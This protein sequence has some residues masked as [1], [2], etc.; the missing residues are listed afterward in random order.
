MN[1]LL[2]PL[3]IAGVVEKLSLPALAQRGDT[4]SFRTHPAKEIQSTGL[5]ETYVLVTDI[6]CPCRSK[7]VQIKYRIS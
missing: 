6:T 1:T 5:R 3:P 4:A 2:A 7:E